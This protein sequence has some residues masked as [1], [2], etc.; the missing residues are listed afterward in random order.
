MS[1]P[2]V[3]LFSFANEIAY[4][5]NNPPW[6]TKSLYPVNTEILKSGNGKNSFG[7]TNITKEQTIRM[8]TG[9]TKLIIKKSNNKK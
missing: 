1:V 9:G 5:Y 2:S 6:K 4:F 3:L 8:Y 7:L